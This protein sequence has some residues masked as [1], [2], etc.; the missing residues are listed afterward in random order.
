MSVRYI[1]RFPMG[2]LCL[3]LLCIAGIPSF[4]QA[5]AN[6]MDPARDSVKLSFVFMGCNRIQHKDWKKIKTDDPSSANLAQL[7]Q[8]FQDIAH[9]D[10]VPPYLFF[11]GD[12]VVNLEDDDG[13]A[14]K[15]QLDAWTVLYKASPLAE[16]MTL[17]PL[18]GN[19]EMLKKVG[20]D[21]DRDEELEVPN[22]AT[23]A[24]W[25][26]WLRDSG[27]DTF[28]K[29]A[30]GPTNAPPNPDKIADDQSEMT[31]SFNIGDVHFIVINTDT[32]T[33]DIDN[34]TKAPY[35]GW[36]PY[37]WIEQDIRSAQADPK[38][39]AIFLIGHKPIMDHPQAEEK[40][41]LNTRKHPLGDQLQA[42]FQANDKIRAYLCAHEHLWECSRLK[43]A[44][45]VWQVIAGNAGSKL[46]SKWDPPEGTFFGFS[47]I[48]AYASGKVGLVNYQRPTPKPPQ[49]YFE[50]APVSPAVAQPQPEIT[51][52]PL[53]R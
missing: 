19:H 25:L 2:V 5:P 23:N 45:Q 1:L 24:R 17:V 50:R 40:A 51:L 39:S 12:L 20:D 29:M 32:L 26:K 47:Q 7:R 53:G 43:K 41:I 18:P 38:L 6:P 11:M 49:K 36:V 27:F 48:N 21:K 30:N 15:K 46:N 42:L 28:A 3:V 9:L 10:P 52:F 8:T 16:K 37:H 13:K 4:G 34:D 31:Y 35:I 22:P 33:T 14:L 44:P